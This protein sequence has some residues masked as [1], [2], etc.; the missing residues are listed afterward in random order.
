MV[1]DSAFTRLKLLAELPHMGAAPEVVVAARM[2]SVESPA[3][4]TRTL[5]SSHP[6]FAELAERPTKD[7]LPHQH[8]QA[9]FVDRAHVDHEWESVDD[10][11]EEDLP[12]RCSKRV[13]N[14]DPRGYS[15]TRAPQQS[16]SW[17]ALFSQTHEQI[18]PLAGVIV[19]AALF[20]SAALMF[21][22]MFT[23][24]QGN[25]ELNE[26]ALPG[27]GFCVELSEP[28]L[29][30]T[31]SLGTPPLAE[32]S[33]SPS[34]GVPGE[35]GSMPTAMPSGES[36]AELPTEISNTTLQPTIEPAS[37]PALL[38]QLLFPV[39]NTPLELD[40]SKA[41]HNPTEDLQALPAIAERT[42]TAT[43]EPINR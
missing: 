22:M 8:R 34:S 35:F 29:S 3:R 32:S 7:V 18:A 42:D 24:R 40:Y 23:S 27:E 4:S 10:D 11:R 16:T 19:T 9:R 1:D 26:F 31:N 43:T 12:R 37:E 6:A 2:S 14:R 30:P 38:G 13:S 41:L 25:A 15:H 21:W 33:I 17:G 20:A 5:K 36:P 28:Q 39:T